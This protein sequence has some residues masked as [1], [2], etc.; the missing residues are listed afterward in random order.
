MSESSPASIEQLPI[1]ILVE[2]FMFCLPSGRWAYYEPNTEDAPW[3][4]AQVCSP[5]RATVLSTPQLWQTLTIDLS[6]LLPDEMEI[7][8]DSSSDMGPSDDLSDSVSA[9]GGQSQQNLI[10]LVGLFVER[11]GSCPFT[12]I[13][14]WRGHA[15]CELHPVLSQVV[16]MLTRTSHRWGN[17]TYELPLPVLVNLPSVKGRV[18]SLRTLEISPCYNTD[19]GAVID[20]FVDAP[21][22]QSVNV[23]P[24]TP[25][26]SD[27]FPIYS[28]RFVRCR[29]LWFATSCTTDFQ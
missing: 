18:Q 20:E 29:I 1:E 2:I 26:V 12:L 22:L 6:Q 23:S 9:V 14:S 5:W 15:P 27:I 3:V 7:N 11:S 10:H 28:T 8:D 17:L 24:H 25:A 13:F 19:E 4:L 16:E 21:L